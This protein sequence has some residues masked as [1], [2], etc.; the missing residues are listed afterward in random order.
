MSLRTRLNL[1]AF[2]LLILLVA[3]SG[4]GG[5]VGAAPPFKTDV[6][7]VLVV[8][9]ST[10]GDGNAPVWVNSTK[11]GGVRDYVEA[12]R[13]GKFRLLDQHNPT[14]LVNQEWKDALAVERKSVPWIVAAGPRSGFSRALPV[15]ADETLKLLEGVK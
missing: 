3:V 8:E 6:L 15:S 4:G 13:K 1:N 9:E 2:A 10:P 14:G 12:T 7:A 5:I 11:A